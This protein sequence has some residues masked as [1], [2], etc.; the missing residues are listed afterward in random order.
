M[1]KVTQ[2]S[3][4]LPRLV[5]RA[6]SQFGSPLHPIAAAVYR[7]GAAYP[8]A[9]FVQI[10]ANDGLALDPLRAQ[11]ERR[12]WH[13]IMVEPVPYVFKRLEER[14][15]GH[16]RVRLEQAA[17]ADRAGLLP[18]YHLREASEEDEVWHWYHALG[19]FRREVVLRHK[20]LIPDIEDRLVETKVPCITFGELCERGGL[21]HLDLLQMD[22]EGY[23]YQI[24]RTID[25]DVWRPRLIVYEHH[26]L[27]PAEQRAARE[28]L[29]ARGYLTFEQGLDT[30]ALDS[31]RLGRPD[32]A[33]HKLFFTTPDH[34]AKRRHDESVA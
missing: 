11:V 28:L 7:F 20:S 19:S 34:P 12:R 22:T 33:L 17:I 15:G 1:T 10:G 9:T 14:Y 18:F 27:S 2:V 5:A 31:T 21:T 23:D 29:T 6:R 25:L 3:S 32:K 24:L 4:L 16:P 30:A 13:G 26:H 8:D